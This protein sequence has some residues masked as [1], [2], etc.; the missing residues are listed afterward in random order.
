MYLCLPFYFHL[1]FIY[2]NCVFVYLHLILFFCF[3]QTTKRVQFVTIACVCVWIYQLILNGCIRENICNYFTFSL[4]LPVC[5]CFLFLILILIQTQ[6]C[7]I[8][9]LLRYPRS[10]VLQVPPSE[11]I[12]K[13]C[14]LRF[15]I[16][17]YIFYLYH[18]LQGCSGFDQ[19]EEDHA[20]F[21]TLL[22]FRFS[23]IL[24][25]LACVIYSYILFTEHEFTARKKMFFIYIIYITL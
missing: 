14:V 11:R 16:S 7:Q 9:L 18:K 23:C 2:I 4:N 10:R 8:Y 3:A 25:F 22:S 12:F 24:F 21:S 5:F 19:A 1:T 15:H 17:L 13:G 20:S 6:F